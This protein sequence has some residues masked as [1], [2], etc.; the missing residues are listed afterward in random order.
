M[1]DSRDIDAPA[2]HLDAEEDSGTLMTT[3]DYAQVVFQDV[4][5]SYL[6][7]RQFDW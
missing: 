4:E 2:T 6:P 3:S 7:G 1:A 5:E